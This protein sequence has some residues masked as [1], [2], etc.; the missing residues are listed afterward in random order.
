MTQSSSFAP[1]TIASLQRRGGIGALRA[2]R[3]ARPRVVNVKAVRPN[4]GA[5]P[6]PFMGADSMPMPRDMY[7]GTRGLDVL[8][9]QKDLVAEGFLSPSEATG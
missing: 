9:M 3:R 7:E 2:G 4:P 5:S 1:R 8:A 6:A